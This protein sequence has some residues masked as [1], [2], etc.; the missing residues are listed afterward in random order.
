MFKTSI[1]KEMGFN[2]YKKYVK[3][4]YPP[5]ASGNPM[6]EIKKYE[7]NGENLFAS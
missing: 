3:K 2:E 7:K 4:I 1:V 6:E 5:L